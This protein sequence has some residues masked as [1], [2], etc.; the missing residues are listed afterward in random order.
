MSVLKR[1]GDG[2]AVERDFAGEGEQIVEARGLQ[3][4]KDGVDRLAA[5]GHVVHEGREG[6]A[7][8]I[9][10]HSVDFGGGVD[11]IDAPGFAQ[12]AGFDLA[13]A[14]FFAS[15]GSGK[16]E[17]AAGAEAEDA[18]DDALLAHGDADDVGF[19]AATIEEAHHGDVVGEGFGG[20]DDFDELGLEGQDAVKDGVEIPGGFVVVVADDEGGAE[21]AK[22]LHLRG[23]GVLGGLQFDVDEMAAGLGG[24]LEDF[25]LSGDGAFE[26]SAGGSAT[27]GGDGGDLAAL[28]EKL[29]EPGNDGERIGKIVEAKFDEMI[30]ADDFFGIAH[31][32][33]GGGAGDGDT[34]FSD[35]GADEMGRGDCGSFAHR[36]AVGGRGNGAWPRRTGV[37]RGALQTIGFRPADA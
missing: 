28:V 29:L 25:K 31:H 4:Q 37:G 26:F 33:G 19:V 11:L 15:V 27:A 14:G 24:L 22:L 18:A 1:H 13:G 7:D 10:G 5:E 12:G 20:G 8:G 23:L 9:A 21:G 2:E 17:D 6:V 3:R 32:V 35:A 16:G 30:F 34:N 36:I